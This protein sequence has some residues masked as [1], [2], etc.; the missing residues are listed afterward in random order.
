MSIEGS[1]NLWVALAA[2][3]LVRPTYA[4]DDAG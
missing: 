4:S 3:L 2:S 1:V